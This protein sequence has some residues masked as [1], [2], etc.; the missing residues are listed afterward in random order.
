VPETVVPPH[1]SPPAAADGGQSE[2][3]RVTMRSTGVSGYDLH[4]K[5]ILANFEAI[6]YVRDDH[7][8]AYVTDA[9]KNWQFVD[10]SPEVDHGPLGEDG[11]YSVP[12][13]LPVPDAGVVYPVAS[14]SQAEQALAVA[15]PREDENVPSV[16]GVASEEL[17]AAFDSHREK[18]QQGA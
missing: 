16:G 9:Q 12:A 17:R 10:V 7:L 2:K 11:P 18:L 14:G 5:P 8:D 3:R 15:E 1:S 6:D 4:G 13:H